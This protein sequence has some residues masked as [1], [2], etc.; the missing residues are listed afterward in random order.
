MESVAALHLG[1]PGTKGGYGLGGL[2]LNYPLEI[3][4]HLRRAAG[5]SS[6]RCDLYYPAAQVAVEYDSDRYHQ[7]ENHIASDSKRRTALE[8]MGVHVI[9]LTRTQLMDL[10]AMDAVAAVVD[11]LLKRELPRVRD[12]RTRQLQMRSQLLDFGREL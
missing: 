10:D 4:V 11:R 6:V 5:R 7:A 2:R 12:F 1:L 9:S 8:L 3:P